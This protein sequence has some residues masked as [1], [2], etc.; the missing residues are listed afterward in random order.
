MYRLVTPF[1]P[2]PFKMLL[3]YRHSKVTIMML[4]LKQPN[5][6]FN[7]NPTDQNPNPHSVRLANLNLE[8]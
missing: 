6:N 3:S 8:W 4:T 5:T 1:L 7:P 2:A